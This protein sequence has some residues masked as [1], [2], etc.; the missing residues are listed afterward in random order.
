[1]FISLRSWLF[2]CSRF[3]GLID[4]PDLVFDKYFC[5]LRSRERNDDSSYF[6]KLD[7][8]ASTR[9]TATISPAS[10]AVSHHQQQTDSFTP[11]PSSLQV[12]VVRYCWLHC[13]FNSVRILE[14]LS[15]DND[16]GHRRDPVRDPGSHCGDRSGAVNYNHHPYKDHTYGVNAIVP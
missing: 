9:K 7:S 3:L 16:H 1:L 15:G 4:P 5:G 11:M 2:F 8:T 6:V 12:S 13:Y 14:R 10:A